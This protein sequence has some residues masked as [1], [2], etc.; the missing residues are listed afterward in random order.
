MT[1]IG[2]IKKCREP[3]SRIMF[4]LAYCIFFL[5]FP[6]VGSAK[7]MILVGIA[8]GTCSGKT[9]LAQKLMD[10]YGEDALLIPEDGYY[11]DLTRLTPEER[12]CVNFDHPDALDFDLLRTHLMALKRH[13]SVDVPVYDFVTHTRRQESH[14]V[15]P[16]RL[17]FVEG[18]LLFAVPQIREMFDIKIF[19]DTD[20]DVR[21][22]RRIER[23]ISE[24][25]RTF[26]S[27]KKQYLTSVKPMHKT[28]V[29]PSREHA[30]VVVHGVNEHLPF[31][32]S[33]INGFY[34]EE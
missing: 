30:D 17:I 24:R 21:V 14:V 5:L 33:M 8:G 26:E 15:A 13:E 2:A 31:I 19:V 23:D 27:V 32:V 1:Y 3:W 7:E 4:R 12:D 10:V 20:D 29:K 25:G 22:L 18:I 9:T 16:K 28:F 11:R 6:F 34:C